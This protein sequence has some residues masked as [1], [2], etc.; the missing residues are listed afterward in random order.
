VRGVVYLSI[1]R[2]TILSQDERAHLQ[3]QEIG[4]HN[5]A[6]KKKTVMGLYTALL[7]YTTKEPGKT[8]ETTDSDSSTSSPGL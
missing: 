1:F 7:Q 2:V 3:R 5:S 8:C 4:P 6:F